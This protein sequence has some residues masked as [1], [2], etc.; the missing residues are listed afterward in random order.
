MAKTIQKIGVVGAGTMGNGIAQT[1]AV[2]GY[3]V[4]LCDVAQQALDR[5]VATVKNSLARLASK[6]KITAA[7]ADAA[8]GRIKATT[9]MEDFHDCDLI[10]EAVVERFEVKKAII[11]ELD[12]ICSEDTILASNTSSISLTRIAATSKAPQRVIGMHFF[13]PVPMMQLVEIIRALQTSDEVA[14]T[15]TAL[16]GA[17]GKQAHTSKDSYGFVVNRVLIPMVNEA[18]NCVHEGVAAPADVDAMMKLG[19][20]I[21]WVRCRSPT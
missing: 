9:T 11:A 4:V 12:R 1:F 8:F 19:A 16:V 7:D 3:A 2:S 6:E 14:A 10:V 20:A 5:G 17:I 15:V 21:P 13:N 18:I